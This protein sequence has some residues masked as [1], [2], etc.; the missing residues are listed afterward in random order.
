[1]ELKKLPF[2]PESFLNHKQFMEAR[3]EFYQ[4]E[5]VGKTVQ[6]NSVI[7]THRGFIRFDIGEKVRIRDA[8]YEWFK[9]ERLDGTE[10]DSIWNPLCLDLV[11]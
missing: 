11:E 5:Y 2:Y 9:L 7:V 8:S 1:M 3:N 6:F 4:K 10:I